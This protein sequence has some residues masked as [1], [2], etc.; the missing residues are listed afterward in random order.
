MKQKNG[1]CS[2]YIRG[3]KNFFTRRCVGEYCAQHNY[4]IKIGM[5]PLL[6]CRVCKKGIHVDYRLCLDCGGDKLRHKLK[7]KEIKAIKNFQL[8][9]EEIKQIEKKIKI[10]KSIFFLHL[11]LYI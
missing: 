4:Q 10:L 8:V 5:K 6:P 3:Q 7:R 2:W 1:Q 9:L 11:Y